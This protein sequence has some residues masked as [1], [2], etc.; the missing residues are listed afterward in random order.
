MSIAATASPDAV[1]GALFAYQQTAALKAAI[2]LDL[3]TAIDEGASDPAALAQKSGAAPRGIR[4]LCDYL[5]TIDMLSKTDGRYQL[6]PTS[7]AFLSR[8]SRTYMGTTAQFLTLPQLKQNFDDLT[9]AVTRGGVRPDGNTVAEENPIWVEF[10][11]AMVPMAAGNAHAIAGILDIPAG[12]QVRV[13]DIAAGHGM[14]GIVL[15]QRNPNVQVTAVDWAPVLTVATEHARQAGVESRHQTRPGDAFTVDLGSGYDLALVTNFLHH[16]NAETNTTFLRRIAD[17][18]KPSGQVAIVEFVPN[19]DRVT[20][21]MAA[22][23]SL[24]MLAGTPEGDAYTLDEL[25]AMLDG[26]GFRDVRAHAL[27]TP[28]TLIVA[29]KR[30]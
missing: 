12:D 7:A 16:F 17:A 4:I 25:T 9:G 15:A 2:D 30:S 24:T 13:L 28:Q 1:F 5:T 27:P 18:L 8:K 21:P 23:F 20:P 11:R 22:R 26:A 14:Y 19:P 10:A 6:T 3:F 29:R